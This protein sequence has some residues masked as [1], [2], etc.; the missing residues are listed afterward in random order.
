MKLSL[1][2][3]VLIVSVNATGQSPFTH[4][5]DTINIS[6]VVIRPDQKNAGN[7]IYK[8][9]GIDSTLMSISGQM[10]VGEILTWHSPVFIK[11]YGPEGTAT[12]SF[13]GTG[14]G[15]T[16]VTWNG[17]KL[18]HPMVG[19]ADLSLLPSGMTDEL[20]IYY[21]GASM[22]SGSG[23]TGG[24]IALENKPS[25]DDRTSVIISSSAGSFNRYSGQISVRTGSKAFQSVTRAIVS[26]SL[27]NFSYIN[28]IYSSE[29]F[30]AVRKNNNADQ[31]GFM[32][33]LYYRRSENVLSLRFWYQTYSR[34][35]PA[36]LLVYPENNGGH[37]SDENARLMV[38]YDI[39]KGD[40]NFFITGAIMHSRLNYLNTV[41]AIDSRNNS[42]MLVFKSGATISSTPH[43][44]LDLL[45]NEEFC[46][47]NSNNYDDIAGRNVA[48]LSVSL[49]SRNTGRA[50]GNILLREI[51]YNNELL[52]PDFSG[53]AFLKTGSEEYYIRANFSRSSRIPSMND[54]FW[55]PGGNPVLKN[56]YSYISELSYEINE[57]NGDVFCLKSDITLYNNNINNMIRWRP[58]A[59][60]VW[61]AENVGSARS[62]GIETSLKADYNF[63]RIKA[64]LS[65]GYNYTR[66]YDKE[67]PLKSQLIY[68]PASQMN[69]SMYFQ[70]GKIVT[71]W[72]TVLTG[73]RFTDA[74]NSH[75]LSPFFINSLTAGFRHKPSWGTIEF[76][77]D[78]ENIFNHEY[79]TM[80]Y[81][82]LPGRSYR[83][84][85]T[86]QILTKRR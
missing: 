43:S 13:R 27:N 77:I 56:E 80:A 45:L 72:K 3:I 20:N 34:N 19:Q 66:A 78:A 36:S 61:T 58:G 32:Q 86:T 68:I 28:R 75:Y 35:I 21:G 70:Y 15:N 44:V 65:G 37:Q 18:D 5:P 6:E 16:N 2:Y 60:S 76:D 81:Y 49:T 14:A 52:I 10:T 23:A 31:E 9:S 48:D 74:D 41:S 63:D 26:S 79:Q 30:K 33:E 39:K 67:D 62:Y 50:G 25:W 47:V 38:N 57:K 55:F 53:G 4:K 54:L 17:V 22:A 7:I 40:N 84:R 85:I 46:T 42:D 83:I 73:R 59:S 64:T 69:A 51:M 71:A 12:P 8:K 29:S 24:V 11:N 82:P 1:I